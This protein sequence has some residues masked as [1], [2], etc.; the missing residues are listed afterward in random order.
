VPVTSAPPDR[1]LDETPVHTAD[2]PA[3]PQRDRT[4]P[5]TAWAEAPAALV[6][7]GEDIGEDLVAYKRRIGGWLL[8]RA[9]PAAKARA[10]YM[11]VADDLSSTWTFTLDAT[12]AGVGVGPDG[13]SHQRFRAWKEA[14]RD[15]QP[16][17]EGGSDPERA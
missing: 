8:W 12:G 15:V 17:R 4:I 5:A 16:A 14:L 3:T 11:A 2:L 6:A 10:R 9:G 1:P 13:V 7:L